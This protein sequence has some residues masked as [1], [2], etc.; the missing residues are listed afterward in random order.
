MENHSKQGIISSEKFKQMK[1]AELMSYVN[2]R[3][4]GPSTNYITQSE[5]AL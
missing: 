1:P 3:H 5:S 2:S 4:I